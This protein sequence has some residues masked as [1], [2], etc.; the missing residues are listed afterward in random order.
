MST[1]STASSS[2]KQR[3]RL[4]ARGAL[5]GVGFRPF[6]YRLARELQLCGWVRND[7][8]GVSI[9][10]E[11]LKDRLDT[12]IARLQSELPPHA[13][14]ARLNYESI[15]SADEDSF[16]IK[17]S[18][19]GAPTARV[20]PDLAT[21]PDCLAEIFDP[22]NRRFRYPFTNCTH[23]G[24]RFSIIESIPYDR[25]NTTM[26]QFA[27]CPACREEYGDPEDRRFHAQPN[28]CP[29]CGPRLALWDAQGRIME[30]KDEAL[31]AC[32]QAILAG[33]IAAV[34]G[35]GGFHLICDASNQEAVK[36]LRNRKNR[37]EKPFA[38]MAPSL[39]SVKACC[40]VSAS[41][42]ALLKSAEAPIMLLQ[43][44]DGADAWVCEAV[45][46]ANP[47]LGV[48]LPYTPLHHL[49]L[50][51]IKRPV[52]ATSGNRS[53]EPIC[54]DEN[55]AL[56]RLARLADLFLVHDRPIKRP[57][58]D[59]IVRVVAGRTMI[60][61]RARGY[62]PSP[63]VVDVQIPPAVALGGQLKNTVAISLNHDV[64]LSQHIGDL[65]TGPAL[66][67]HRRVRQDLAR[68]YG[69][70]PE[71]IVCDL[72]PDY[73]STHEAQ[74]MGAPVVS[75]QHHLA[76]VFSCMAEN[77]L[78]PSL[79]GVAW[80]G[81]GYGDDGLVWGG[82]FFKVDASGAARI[83]TLRSFPLPGGEAAIREGWRT[84]IGMLSELGLDAD[85]PVIAGLFPDSWDERQRRNLFRM[86][87]RG[88]NCPRSTS[89]GRLFDAVA[90]I[91]GVC[92]A[93]RYEGQA[94][95]MLEYAASGAGSA[96]SKSYPFSIE[97]RLGQSDVP[98]KSDRSDVSD[99]EED[100]K[101]VF[102]LDWAPIL[103]AM[104]EDLRQHRDAADIAAAFHW[105]LAQAI[106]AMADHAGQKQVAL[107][108]GCFQ[109]KTLL[110]MTIQA[111]AEK[112][113][114][115]HWH[116]QVPPGDGGLALGQL[117]ALGFRLHQNEKI[118]SDPSDKSD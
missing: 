62:A 23:C 113:Y 89:A 68:L 97:R 27:M 29:E 78:K 86:I 106:V 91:C 22:G 84:A 35:L 16:T 10:I 56:T 38:L 99:L 61:R 9:E 46:P 77:R 5:Q 28:A 80:D 6:V 96:Q 94:A 17:A 37:E 63:V 32:A 2:L 71:R 13:S 69:H 20:L 105:T 24:P 59:S 21:C 55:E 41:E 104:L 75:V 52:V 42:E 112:D 102:I 47:S 8:S 92:R 33:K 4:E 30:R 79:L 31:L 58:D 25:T 110:E 93:N 49:L 57:I 12:F 95:M 19:E 3:L 15:P 26:K 14:I 60:L 11:G 103:E 101:A 7:A 53:D 66:D 98:D 118:L 73:V 100:E 88:A 34:K 109:N 45:A 85:A 115:P 40:S 18:A 116:R 72:H 108:G 70:Q 67:A 81:T 48:M 111:L 87:E 114:I 51:A 117:A 65:D 74:R 82:E 83:G 43:R 39:E 36:Q 54:I 90:A 1:K 107:S 50:D 64:Y 76:H 44:S